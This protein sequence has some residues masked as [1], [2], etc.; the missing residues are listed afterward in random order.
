[1]KC[2]IPFL[3]TILVLS[4]LS[5]DIQ[6]QRT[7]TIDG[8]IQDADNREG[9]PGA[10]ITLIGTFYGAYSEANGRFQIQRVPAGTYTLL[11]NYIGYDAIER[12]V[13]VEA[14]QRITENFLLRG[15]LQELDDVV[16]R[17]VLQGQARAMNQQR[18]ASNIKNIVS[19]EQLQRFPD[20]NLASALQRVPGVTTQHDRGEAG[21]IML[22]GLQ[23]GFTS[24]TVNGQRMA[25]T[26]PEDREVFLAGV[27]A[28]MISSLEVTKAITP[29]MDADAVAGSINLVTA[30][31]VGD[32]P[33]LNATLGGGYNNNMSDKVNYRGNITAGQRYGRITALINANYSM[34]HRASEDLRLGYATRT[35]S[36][37]ES[38]ELVRFRP[39][40]HLIERE[41]YGF[42]GQF[43]YDLNSQTKFF[44][45]GM[46]NQY[47]DKEERHELDLDIGRGNY[48]A[49][50]EVT[51]ARGRANRQGRTY[52]QN[53]GLMNLT[54]GGSHDL[55]T[56]NIDYQGTISRG[57]YD[58][59]F[60]N[61]F[62]FRQSGLDFTYDISDM[63]YP[64]YQVIG[65]DP[66]DAND[67]V[68]ENYETRG[69]DALDIDYNASINLERPFFLGSTSSI[70]KFGA[71]I[72]SKN[73]EREHFRRRYDQ[74]DGTGLS[75][76]S[77]VR[78]VGRD[79]QGR[80]NIGSIVD[81]SA[82]T[83]FYN[84]NSNRFG[85]SPSA[86]IRAIN[87]TDPNTYT[88]NEN[89][90]A[91]YLQSTFQFNR[92]NV[93]AGARIEF[94][95]ATYSANEIR[96][97]D[98]GEYIGTQKMEGGSDYMNIFPM[99]H[100]RYQL[101]PRTNLRL[102][103]TSTIARPN[104]SDLA[105]TMYIDDQS[106]RITMGNAELKPLR[107]FNVD[108]LAEHFL[109]DV[110]IISGGVFLKDIKDFVY[111][112]NLPLTTGP[113]AGY[114]RFMPVNGESAIIYGFEVS[115]QQ[116]LSFL[117]G[118]LSG[119]GVYAN[120]TYTESEAKVLIPEERTVR[121]PRQVPH[122]ANI[123][124]S[125]NYS[126][127]QI[128]SS[129]VYQSSYIYNPQDVT[130]AG[131][132]YD[133][134]QRGGWSLDVSASQRVT[135]NLRA[136]MEL[137]NLTNKPESTFYGPSTSESLYPY[138]NGFVSWWGSMGIRYDL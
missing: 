46:F 118:F 131:V 15:S 92:L 85:M 12:E 14:G 51:G 3:T 47:Y 55:E 48:T 134:Y 98:S 87:E 133:R 71:K 7:G 127:F 114:D 38:V 68:F 88:A 122:I 124:L 105:P 54:L 56:W 28:D 96:F 22:R 30:R 99:L 39:S 138:R 110:G 36:G 21:N 128:Q 24:V 109:L 40:V 108:L 34:D 121:M 112:Q 69:E 113:F 130:I 18:T 49:P 137:N 25:T 33:L 9:L 106:E 104:F 81:W 53:N 78:D 80:W 72:A 91:G 8:V 64:R 95:D 135:S 43:D 6:A 16:V 103:L 76:A 57:R 116:N 23:P 66:N 74:F 5:T 84:A 132:L 62:N 17:A 41:R 60:R 83:A 65:K 89:V 90:Y 70:L 35:I 86:V 94:T 59:P 120:Y 93:L 67:Y 50:G 4:V 63:Q 61:Y 26:G 77:F 10:S 42:S 111:V 58:E 123:S 52:S 75:L 97:N 79:H 115:W 13:E 101:Q 129:W 37:V 126:G 100:F 119:L 29:D 82:A 107:S 102:A 136:F 125:Y 44:L 19:S 32:R 2:I 27:S 117:P 31:P 1:M 45:S 11:V 20:P 73:K